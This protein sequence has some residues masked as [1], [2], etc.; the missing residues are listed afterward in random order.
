MVKEEGKMESRTWGGLKRKRL[1]EKGEWGKLVSVSG[2][3]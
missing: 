2:V 1:R 3:E